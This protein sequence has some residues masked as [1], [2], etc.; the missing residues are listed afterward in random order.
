MTGRT[1]SLDLP[2]P[3]SVNASFAKV[4]GKGRL[5]TA[6]YR[7]WQKQA[8]ACIAVQA[9]GIAF[10]GTF[11]L[12]ALAS[13]RDADSLGKAVAD[14][15]T[16]AGGIAD[17]CQ[18]PMRSICIARTPKL[19]PGKGRVNMIEWAA[20]PTQKSAPGRFK[21]SHHASPSRASADSAREGIGRRGASLDRSCGPCTQ[22]AAI[23]A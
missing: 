14:V 9:R 18:Q 21:P 22:T 16:R 20:M 1:F 17:D 2:M 6:E 3:P 4:P 19:E 10:R 11:R 5:H 12:V 15:L 23:R 7:A 8:L 13:D